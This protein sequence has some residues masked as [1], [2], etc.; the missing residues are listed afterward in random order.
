MQNNVTSFRYIIRLESYH[1]NSI[2]K[3]LVYQLIFFY[4]NE[5]TRKAQRTYDFTLGASSEEN[6]RAKLDRWKTIEQGKAT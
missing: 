3:F 5:Y 4:L 6:S 1:P 2:W